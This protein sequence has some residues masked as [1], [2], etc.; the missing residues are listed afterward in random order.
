MTAAKRP[1]AKR[2]KASPGGGRY[3]TRTD[4][5]FRVKEARYQLRQSPVTRDVLRGPRSDVTGSGRPATNPRQDTRG[6]HPVL[7]T[8]E[9]ALKSIKRLRESETTNTGACGCSAVGSAQPCQGWGREFESR[10]PLECTGLFSRRSRHV[11]SNHTVNPH[12][13]VAERLGTGLQ[14]RL[15]GFE[16]RRHLASQLNTPVQARLA[17]R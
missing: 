7:R 3:R 8:A 12:G 5:L 10:H 16:S 1:P 6:A 17:Q 9:S 11:G 13:G 2:Q 15:H 4:D 14:S